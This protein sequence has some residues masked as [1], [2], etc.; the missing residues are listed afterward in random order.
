MNETRHVQVWC[1]LE[2]KSVLQ[3]SEYDWLVVGKSPVLGL[4]FIP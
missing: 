1:V 2:A 4:D 3:L